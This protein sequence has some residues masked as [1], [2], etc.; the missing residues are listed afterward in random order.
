MVNKS[1][2]RVILKAPLRENTT[3]GMH[4]SMFDDKF[5][6][7]ALPNDSYNPFE[8]SRPRDD[9]SPER[10]QRYPRLES[11][12]HNEY[13]PYYF[14]I[15]S[16]ESFEKNLQEAQNRLGISPR[17][18]IPV[19]YTTETSIFSDPSALLSTALTGILIYSMYSMMRGAAGKGGGG[20]G[21]IFQ[22]GKST[23]KKIKKEQVNVSFKDVAG[24]DEAKKEIMEFVGTFFPLICGI[25]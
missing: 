24:C 22:I 20:I 1:V 11:N 8:A 18:Y 10:F 19:V 14:T 6:S 16:V 15:G 7:G 4:D 13:S 2:A 25:I 9:L 23:A 21:N 3:D 12:P 17:D 5:A